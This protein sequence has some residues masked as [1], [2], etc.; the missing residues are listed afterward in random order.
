MPTL[1]KNFSPTLNGIW[2][3]VYQETDPIS[4][5]RTCLLQNVDERPSPHRMHP[6][7]LRPCGSVTHSVPDTGTCS[8]G[9]LNSGV[10]R[11][12]WLLE[13]QTAWPPLLLHTHLHP[14]IHSP[15]TRFLELKI[16]GANVGGISWLWVRTTRI[17][18]C[19]WTKSHY[20]CTILLLASRLGTLSTWKISLV[21]PAARPP[22]LCRIVRCQRKRLRGWRQ[23]LPK[24]ISRILVCLIGGK[25]PSWLLVPIIVIVFGNNKNVLLYMATRCRVARGY[26]AALVAFVLSTTERYNF[27][28]PRNNWIIMMGYSIITGLISQSFSTT[29]ND[30]SS[31]STDATAD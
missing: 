19:I 10:P 14:Q 9:S 18:N 30:D 6:R 20:K 4:I 27:R 11:G 5:P 29:F 23:R 13:R 25:E 21:V 17:N 26:C 12:K 7:P 3:M 22:R 8:V 31:I 28:L 15:M 1:K 24:K 2:T 16:L